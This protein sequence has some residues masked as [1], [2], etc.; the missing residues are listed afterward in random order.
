MESKT[1]LSTLI[2]KCTYELIGSPHFQPF[3][4]VIYERIYF[5]ARFS[6]HQLRHNDADGTRR[7]ERRIKEKRIRS[8]KNDFEITSNC[9]INFHPC[10]RSSMIPILESR[11][12]FNRN[13]GSFRERKEIDLRR[14]LPGRV[15]CQFDD[16]CFRREAILATSSGS[17]FVWV[18]RTDYAGHSLRAQQRRYYSFLAHGQCHY[19]CD[20]GMR[21]HIVCIY[22]Y[23]QERWMDGKRDYTIGARISLFMGWEQWAWLILPMNEDASRLSFRWKCFFKPFFLPLCP[24]RLNDARDSLQMLI[25]KRIVV[26]GDWSCRGQVHMRGS[27]YFNTGIFTLCIGQLYP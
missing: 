10:G 21:M 2:R 19:F 11:R 3:D 23:T 27:A 25:A 22:I 17:R 12:G 18:S 8:I 9:E 5:R 14:L 1:R 26:Y 4:S 15:N 13:I 20:R 24:R 16:G 6:A 7:D